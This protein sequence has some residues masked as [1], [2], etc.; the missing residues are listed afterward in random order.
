MINRKVN[1]QDLVIQYKKTND[2]KL[3]NQIAKIFYDDLKRICSN[4]YK[5]YNYYYT[6]SD[7]MSMIH[8]YFSIGLEKYNINSNINFRYFIYVFIERRIIDEIRRTA[9][10]RRHHLNLIKKGE[11][12]KDKILL[13]RKMTLENNFAKNN[14]EE[15]FINFIKRNYNIIEVIK[16]I[17]I[18]N[19]DINERDKKIFVDYFIE[20]KNINIIEN[21]YNLHDYRIYQIVN[22]I[23]NI[24]KKELK[25]K[26]GLDEYNFREFY[27]MY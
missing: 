9:D 15:P 24:I 8:L 11:V 20:K 18:K 26:Y 1:L 16:N 7:V 23:K 5:K 17:V 13:I 4:Q 10:I 14:N 6:K 12:D 22:K 25:S 27:N 2:R 3:K 19:N 21:K